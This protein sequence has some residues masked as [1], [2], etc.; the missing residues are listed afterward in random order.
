LIPDLEFPERWLLF[1]AEVEITAKTNPT[2][3]SQ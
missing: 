3:R 1:G 2:S